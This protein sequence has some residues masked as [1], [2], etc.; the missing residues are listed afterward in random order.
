MNIKL[1]VIKEIVRCGGQAPSGDNLQPWHFVWHPK[2]NLLQL[3]FVPG[4][5][6]SFFD[7]N[8]LAPYIALGAVIE[9]VFLAA[10]HFGLKSEI[11]YFPEG[12]ESLLIANIHFTPTDQPE[13]PLYYYID[14][15][16]VNRKPYY[17]HWPIPKYV[18]EALKKEAACFP[19]VRLH[20]IDQPKLIWRLAK[21]VWQADWIRFE[22]RFLHE[23]LHKKLRFTKEEKE[24]S[25][26]SQTY[27]RQVHRLR[28]SLSDVLSLRCY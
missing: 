8:N 13:D 22:M 11:S 17:K 28:C 10:L 5:G 18:E 25:R 26:K 7:V 12:E 2:D 16:C 1:E 6:N 20:W 24:A 3:F 27:C 9:N 14:K 23:D 4:R 21:L 19:G 15:R